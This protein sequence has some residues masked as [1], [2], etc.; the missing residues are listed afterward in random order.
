MAS[1]LHNW[2]FNPGSFAKIVQ[3]MYLAYALIMMAMKFLYE[4][5]YI[6][7]LEKHI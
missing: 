3:N 7:N 1:K 4:D 6:N 2:D 5:Q